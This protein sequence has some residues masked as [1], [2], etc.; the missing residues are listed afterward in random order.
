MLFQSLVIL[1]SYHSFNKYLLSN[2]CVPGTVL[3]TDDMVKNQTC[4]K[5]TDPLELTVYLLSH[6]P[7]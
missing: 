6:S 3:G 1:K 7:P 2:S 5:V 4:D